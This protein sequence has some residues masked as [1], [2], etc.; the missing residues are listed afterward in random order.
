MAQTLTNS[1]KKFLQRLAPA[2]VLASALSGSALAVEPGPVMILQNLV[3][4]NMPVPMP[5]PPNP[6]SR[7]LL[8]QDGFLPEG[9]IIMIAVANSQPHMFSFWAEDDVH[10][11]APFIENVLVRALPGQP[12]DELKQYNTR[13][14]GFALPQTALASAVIAG[15]AQGYIFYR[16][17]TRTPIFRNDGFPSAGVAQLMRPIAGKEEAPEAAKPPAAA[18]APNASP[19]PDPKVLE[20]ERRKKAEAACAQ[21]KFCVSDAHVAKWIKYGVPAKALRYTF[22]FV[23]KNRNQIKN[24]K[25]FAII[26]YNRHSSEKRMFILGWK[27]GEFEAMI[28]THGSGSDRGHTGWASRLGNED[29]S[30][31]TPR[32]FHRAT[33]FPSPKFGRSLILHGMEARNEDSAD[34]KILIHAAPYATDRFV[35]RFGRPGRSQGCPAVAPNKIKSVIRRLDGYSLVYN[36]KE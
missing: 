34:R 10:G 3:P 24:T 21:D 36:Y 6:F 8:L 30:Y 16:L 23:R 19:T 27:T 4:V 22:E 7:S 15:E 13:I 9:A 26:D 33:F 20:A 5:V 11:Q 1:T 25:Y 29:R 18:P 2:A 28:A 32:G 12:E 31:K 14:G 35:R 17:T